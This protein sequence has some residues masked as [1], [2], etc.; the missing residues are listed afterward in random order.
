MKSIGDLVAPDFTYWTLFYGTI[1]V[2]GS[3]GI[4]LGGR[5]LGKLRGIS[6]DT[7]LAAFAVATFFRE[8]LARWIGNDLGNT[9]F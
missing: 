6:F 9:L 7:F 2:F 5:Q 3:I 8:R 4:V 1:F